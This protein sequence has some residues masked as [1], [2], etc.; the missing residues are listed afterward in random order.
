MEIR[1]RCA[2]CNRPIHLVVD[3]ELKYHV[4]D[5][6][7]HPLVFEPDVDWGEFEEPTIING[8]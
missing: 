5:G 6:G 7:A 1:T 4:K 8:Y 2:H 3:S